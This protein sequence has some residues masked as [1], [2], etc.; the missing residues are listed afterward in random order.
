[1]VLMMM[2]AA[3]DLSQL[4]LNEK[5]TREKLSLWDRR[6]D[7]L[8]PLTE[9][10]TDSILEIQAAAENLPIP[11]EL[12]IEDLCS[13]TSRSISV[14][15][16]VTVPASTE[17]ILLQGFKSLGM[18]D[19]RIET[20]QFFSWFSKL[21]SQMDQDEGAKCRQTR[22]FL[23][24]F[25]EQCDAILNDV[26][27][28]LQ[29]LESLQKQYLFVSMKT[30]TLH[31]ACE[32]LLKEQGTPA[33]LQVALTR[34]C[35]RLH[36][37]VAFFFS[38][39]QLGAF[40]ALV[41][42]MLEDVQERLVYRTH[43]YIQS[44]I[45][46]YNPAPGD[47]A[48]PDKLEM[49]EEQDSNCL[50]PSAS[51]APTTRS[52]ATISPADLHGMWYPTVR[53]TLVCLS[54][55]YRCIDRTVFQGLSQE[56]L[57]A[58]I[59]SSLKAADAI[60]KNKTQI[61]GQLFL[62]KHLL[63]L[64]EQIA[65][66][67]ADF[68]IKEIS[69]DLKKTREDFFRN[70]CTTSFIAVAVPSK[71]LKRQEEFSKAGLTWKK[72]VQFV[73]E[74][75]DKKEQP[76]ANEDLHAVLKAA[77]QIVGAEFGQ[78]M[79]ESAAVFL[80]TTFYAKDQLGQEETRTIK[81]MFGPFPSSSASAACNAVNRVTS[82]FDETQLE[83]FI[84]THSANCLKD[85][86]PFGKNI[87]FSFDLYALDHLEDLP[88]NND[89]EKG[90]KE[91]SLDYDKFVNNQQE[92]LRNGSFD[93]DCPRS[94]GNTDG[95]LLRRE[96]EKYLLEGTL[97]STTAEDLCTTLFESLASTKSDDELQNELFEL[98]GPEG[99]ELIEKLLQQRA[100]IVESSMA[101]VPDLKLNYL[102]DGS[103][104][105]SG[106]S[107]IPIYGC[108][109]TIQ[110]EQEKQLM[111]QYRREEKRIAKREKRWD[112][113]EGDIPMHFDPK[114]LRIQREHALL[115]AQKSPV[116]GRQ[117]T[118]EKIHYPNVYD[119]CA[120]AMKTSAFIGGSKLLLPEGIK[121]ENT[122][123]Y[124]E[125]TIPPNEPMPV[126]FE[127]KPVYI[128]DLD[129]I[130]QLVFK[131]MKRLNRIQSIVFETAYNTN[132]NMLIC[133]P[134]GAGKTNIAM[135]TVVHEIRQHIQQ[136]VIKKDEFKIVY[137]APMKALAAEM[138]NY[139]SKRLEPLGI[140]VKELTGDMQLTKGEI[141]RT[142]EA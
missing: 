30:G 3:V 60:M 86:V 22:D 73:N 58:C 12:P 103:R 66:F 130:G 10:Q 101:T 132:E 5:G 44:D 38:V 90:P 61:D 17:D 72:I 77:R 126:G 11:T 97:G 40:A 111:K 59:Q 110:S 92:H 119:C 41:Q 140:T 55:L 21:Q 8:A 43:M 99:F 71:R 42:Q 70:H 121:R 137:V 87:T 68:A 76:A 85:Q 2:M 32:Q 57:S 89:D 122:K 84:K 51:E 52:Q 133:A 29:H 65:P 94:S 88:L 7:A 104:K 114:E 100:S 15:L 54:K 19:E 34:A 49:M 9:R 127:E 115:T 135:L 46:G 109:V 123:M 105:A 141:L 120:E 33:A 83:T 106:E 39:E 78:D 24:G 1:M 4:D 107:S 23:S 31:E 37:V 64:R 81:Q 95:S 50:I 134:T 117:K 125:V 45:I 47:L 67:H 74:H 16:T 118:Y 25:Q 82:I 102:Q 62:I 80:F 63:I 18:E 113:S 53:R 79:I 20:A 36:Q 14:P 28:A 56:A 139:F 116:L 128:T 13:L 96:V 48:Y 129:E 108:Q 124:E 131:G 6:S 112:D 26:N 35:R 75:L 98:L 69:L 93:K 138:T 27:T 136:G 91:F 142:Q